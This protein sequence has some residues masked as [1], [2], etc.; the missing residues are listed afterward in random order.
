VDLSENV[1]PG[2]TPRPLQSLS[3]PTPDDPPWNT[4]AA[5][6]IW[7]ASVVF[8]VLLPNLILIPYLIAKQ[9]PFQDPAQ[10]TEFIFA[11]PWAVFINVV[12]II[13]AHV[14]TLVLAWVVITRFNRFSFKQ[15][16]GWKSGGMLWWHYILILLIF[17]AIA[18]GV[19]HYYPDEQND[20]MRLLKSSR[21]AVFAIAF[22][23]T[24]TAP[25]V[26]EVIYR[27]ILYS[28]LQRTFGM[29]AAIAIVTFLFS[30]VHVPQYYP[31]YS[32]IFLLT[33][34][35]LVLT[36]I[37]STTR[38][39]LPC[40]ILHFLFNGLQSAFLIAEPWF[41]TTAPDITTASVLIL[42]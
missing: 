36:L 4:P 27:G 34:L 1:P 26:E 14:L 5:I 20:F 30:L 7:L 24:F 3:T 42:K 15:T 25:I 2:L 13:P 23:A 33:L 31:S 39:L 18:A 19:T 11:D 38:N 29:I 32:T 12:A 37:R 10:L 21:A 28:A 41:R 22:M 35:S 8:I 6:G 9:A 40:I 17:F 16:L